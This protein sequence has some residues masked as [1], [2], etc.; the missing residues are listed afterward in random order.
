MST[1]IDE[2]VVAM[3]FD[4]EQFERGTRKTIS[5]L[6]ALKKGLNLDGATKSLQGLDAA[7][8][9]FDMSH[10]ARG[11]DAIASKF[12]AL[13]V[14]GVGALVSIGNKAVAVGAQVINSLTVA[15]INAGLQEYEMNLNAI[16][17]ILASTKSKGEN[18][19]SIGVALDTLN[20]Y[21]DQT[22]YNFGQMVN[23]IK[24]LT[25]AGADLSQG[26]DVVKGFANAAALAGVGAQEMASALNYGLNQAIS[27]GRMMTQ[28]WMSLE[29]A[30]IAS[31]SFKNSLLETARVNGIAVDDM[32]AKN[33]S[34]RESINEGWITSDILIQTLQKY[35]GEMTD[36]QLKSLGYSQEQI[37]A[38]QDLA[39]TAVASATEVKTVSQLMGTLAETAQSG[40]AKTWQLLF[41]DLEEAKTLFSAVNETVGGL[42]GASSEARNALLKD[43]KDLGGRTVLIEG[44]THAWEALKSIFI[45]IKEAFREI[46]PPTTGQQLFDITV[47]IRDFLA[48][49]K[50][51]GPA[52]E[53]LK[54]TFKGLFALLDIGRMII[55]QVFGVLGKLFGAAQTGGGGFLELT[56]NIGDFLVKLRD[57]IKEGNV[58]EKVFS[59]VAKVLRAIGEPIAA[60][61]QKMSDGNP[62]ASFATA[63]DHIANA[64]KAVWEFLK[65]VTDWFLGVWD[66]V[67]KAVSAAFKE[68]DFNVLVGLLNAGLIGGFILMIKKFID[69]IPG[70]LGGI[71]G[72]ILDTIKDAFGGLTD[73]MSAMQDKLKAETLLKI[74]TAIAVLTAAIVVLSFI[75]TEKLA[76]SLS[77]ITIMMGQLMGAMAVMEKITSSAAM[78]KMTLL[79]INLIILS[80]AMLVMA[81]ALAI[82]ATMSWDEIFRGLTGMAGALV[83][84]AGAGMVLSKMS[85]GLVKAAA[86]I[87]VMGIALNVMGGALKIFSTLSWDD[88]LRSLVA[89]G[90]TMAVVLAT[91]KMA[92]SSAQG[93]AAMMIIS[94]ALMI[95]GAALMVMAKMDWDDIGRA[96]A[97]L[98]GSLFIMAAGVNFMQGSVAGAAAMAIVSVSILILSAAFKEFSKMS[99]DDIGRSMVVLGGSLAILAAA[100][101]L[102]GIPLVLLGAVGLAVA[103]A[104]MMLLAP[105]LVMLGSMSWD[106]IGAGLAM[107]ASA[108]GIIAAGGLLLLVAIPGLLGLGAAVLLIG[109]GAMMAG[110]GITAFA[111]GLGALAAMGPVAA[112]S[113]KIAVLTLIGLIPLALAAFAKGLV[114]FAL[115]IADSGVQITAAMVTVLTSL[116]TAIATVA[117]LIVETLFSLIMM[118]VQ[119]L[120]DNVPKLVDAGLQLLTGILN[121]IAKNI[122]GIIDAATNIIVNFINGISRGLPRI[123]QAGIDMIINFVNSLA[124][125]IRQ[126][127][128]RMEAAGRNLAD[129]IIDGMVGGISRGIQSV[130]NAAKRV[131]EGALNAAKSFLGIKSPSREFFKVGAWSTEGM[132]IGLN[133]TAGVVAKASEGVG[134]SAVTAM[135]KSMMGLATAMDGG[136]DLNPTIR[137]VL[138]LTN[139]KKGMGEVRDM[140]RPETIQLDS[141]NVSAQQAYAA[142]LEVAATSNRN[143][144]EGVTKEYTFI[145][146]NNSP[147]ALSSADIYRQ[148]KNQLSKVKEELQDA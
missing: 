1:T 122:G 111:V 44:M 14:I 93:A 146:N 7:G 124:N 3:K 110:I 148:T 145:Q 99:W 73:T 105:A 22:I 75:D 120:L 100:M 125:G 25:T 123:V 51:G 23:G 35:T 119:T 37:A 29:T 102:M 83:I 67:K 15:P 71:G 130:I 16:Q 21:S 90:G 48:S 133:R 4:N 69:K 108:L 18:L 78:G 76:V 103:A 86:G 47:G 92:Q 115:V 31:E 74:A 128:A 72:G 131:A 34:F 80:G 89:I 66:Q 62:M 135:K 65:P 45:P 132:A 33:G 88:I 118:L 141:N 68:M 60:I 8:K 63:W 26:V 144:E 129:A 17:T 147:K 112:E 136:M 61:I 38:I 117:P 55:V 101:A 27:K 138:D 85:G 95:L 9:S 57:A 140:M 39:R 143:T 84:L 106:A 49:L 50:L 28:D 113:I 64:L 79:S 24:T 97:T 104:S 53:N 94:S 59:S 98:A 114:D 134:Y 121:G 70:M 52:A 11:V 13:G 142:A 91:A 36:E 77:A 12:T 82:Y 126:N 43:W 5:S 139:V 10:M 96:L 30:G 19:E 107:L 6:D 20:T 127:T 54:S 42:I 58:I 81:G 116:I 2:K 56:G 109:A 41:G 32:I 137:P 46:F 87:L 40:W